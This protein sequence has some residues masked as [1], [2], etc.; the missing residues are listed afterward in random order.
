[1]PVLT[2]AWCE[3]TISLCRTTETLSDFK[4]YI[5]RYYTWFVLPPISPSP[6]EL[7]S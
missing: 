7:L 3:E 6:R 1:M 4:Y 2:T 5:G